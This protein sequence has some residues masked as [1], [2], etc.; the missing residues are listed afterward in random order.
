[1]GN[2]QLYGISYVVGASMKKRLEDM[3]EPEIKQMMTD[4]GHGIDFQLSRHLIG[5]PMFTLI[6]FNDPKVGQYLS[7]CERPSMIVALKEVAERLE[8]KQDVPR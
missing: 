5:K 4:I 2:T 1:L 8:K 3:T 7:N 6:V